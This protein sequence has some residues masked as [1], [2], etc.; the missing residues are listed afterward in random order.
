MV[1]LMLQVMVTPGQT[2]GSTQEMLLHITMVEQI[3]QSIQQTV[4]TVGIPT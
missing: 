2:L 3:Y 4:T 1:I